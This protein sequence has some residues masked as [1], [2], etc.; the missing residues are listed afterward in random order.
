MF[1]ANVLPISKLQELE[2]SYLGF[3]AWITRGKI[4]LNLIKEN[5]KKKILFSLFPEELFS[6]L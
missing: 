3:E 2:K 4:F 6:D 1:F 5:R